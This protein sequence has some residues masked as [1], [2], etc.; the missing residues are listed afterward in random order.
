M[1]DTQKDSQ[2]KESNAIAYKKGIPVW[3]IS[4]LEVAYLLRLEQK[5]K[6]YWLVPV[7]KQHTD[8][9]EKAGFT[10]QHKQ[11]LQKST[12]AMKMSTGDEFEIAPLDEAPLREFVDEHFVRLIGTTSDDKDIHK[13]YLDEHPY[14]KTRIFR[15]GVQGI[16]V[17]EK[18]EEDDF[19]EDGDDAVD[20]FD[21]SVGLEEER[22][23]H[24]FQELF[25]P[26]KGK[27]VTVDMTHTVKDPS[28]KAYQTWRKAS[29][30]KFNSRKRKFITREN[31]D[32]LEKLYDGIVVSVSGLAIGKSDCKDA[33]RAEWLPLVPL[34]H[35]LLVLDT[36][37][38]EIVSKN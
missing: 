8:L 34:E 29:T 21:I 27:R 36:L 1:A 14:L 38:S 4:A 18:E 22:E 33:N 35:K 7:L 28:E 30:R 11:A 19:F 37:F 32:V 16:T 24:L 15:E 12:P 17:R 23:V 5:G 3:D 20:L 9:Q 10:Y 6:D 25:D 2:P 26:G 31:Y 13:Q